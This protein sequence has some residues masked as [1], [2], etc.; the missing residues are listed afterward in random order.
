LNLYGRLAW[1]G[2][3][4]GKKVVGVDAVEDVERRVGTTDGSEHDGNMC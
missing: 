4:I 1:G 2:R 3:G